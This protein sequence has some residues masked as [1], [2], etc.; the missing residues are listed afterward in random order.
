MQELTKKIVNLAERIEKNNVWRQRD[1]INLI[2]S[3]T[4][5]SALVKICEIS[6]PSGRYAEHRTMKGKEV[7]FYQGI[8]FIREVEEELRNQMAGYF[9]CPRVELRP[10]SGQMANEVIFKA[11]VKFIN[12]NRKEGQPFRKMKL[13]MNNE[14]TKGGHLSSQPMGA[15]FNYVEEDPNTGKENVINFPVRGDCL[16]KTDTNKLAEQLENHKPELIV[17][18][19]SMFL[20]REPVAF[21]HDIVKDWEPRPVIMYDMAHVLG[22]Y[23]VLQEPFKEGADVVTGSTHKTFFGPQRG[24]IAS[25]ISKESPISHLW[26][27]I[28]GRAFPGS[29]SN[30]HLGTLLALLMATYEM[31]AFKDDYQMQIRKNA[32]A[33]AAAL[34]DAGID[35]EGDEKEGFT[36]THQVVIRVKKQGTGN[37]L[38]HRLEQNNIVTNYQALPDDESFLEAS[39]IRMGVQEMT[40]YGMKEDDFRSL[41]GYIADVIIRNTNVK[42]KI[43]TFRRRFIQMLYC[44]P[45]QDSALLVARIFTSIFPDGKFFDNLLE[46]LHHSA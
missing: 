24:I 31:N 3:E 10:V 20:H 42:D 35:V 6:D 15:L 5:P 18:G 32:R 1:C 37:E 30:H 25:T 44:L 7:Y 26:I 38:S 21:V 13:V 45:A 4:T 22:L 17:F 16:Y 43:A 28:K 39:G 14:L 27:D 34:K 12:R 11:M 19:K 46:H 29:T 41:A 8:D 33:F 36:E 23:G 40:R 2:P 9:G